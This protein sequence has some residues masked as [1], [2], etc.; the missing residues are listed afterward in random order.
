MANWFARAVSLNH[1]WSRL[2]ARIAGTPAHS[3][4][5]DQN[6]G[7]CGECCQSSAAPDGVYRSA[8]CQG[9][10]QLP[11]G[12]RCTGADGAIEARAN[13]IESAKESQGNLASIFYHGQSH[14]LSGGLKGNKPS[15]ISDFDSLQKRVT[16][17]QLAFT[18]QLELP[19]EE[20][21]K[22][23]TGV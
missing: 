16:Y 6:L 13:L 4:A 7:A 3:A 22:V 8:L 19:P 18:P 23:W 9:Q 12:S 11:L 1:P 14:P 20:K 10:C 15:S 17:C 5:C 21:G 2:D